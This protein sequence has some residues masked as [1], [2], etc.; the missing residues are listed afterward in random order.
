MGSVLA[1][2]IPI[3]TE[4]MNEFWRFRKKYY[5]PEKSDE[6]NAEVYEAFVELGNKYGG[7][8]YMLDILMA[9]HR[10]YERNYLR[11]RKDE[12]NEII[13]GCDS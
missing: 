8:Q 1:K 9:A 3:E 5:I 2:D 12:G 11:M 7:S 4:F 6:Y 10:E 13:H